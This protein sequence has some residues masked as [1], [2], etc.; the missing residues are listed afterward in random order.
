[1]GGRLLGQ[2]QVPLHFFHGRQ[3]MVAAI[4]FQQLSFRTKQSES[5]VSLFSP[6]ELRQQVLPPSERD[7]QV[8]EEVV[9][10]GR[11]HAPGGC[12]VRR[13]AD[14][15]RASPPARGRVD[16]GRGAADAA[17][18]APAAIAIGRAHCRAAG[19]LISIRRR[20]TAGGRR[21]SR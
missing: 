12:P 3:T 13:V 1:M 21:S 5:H 9:I 20:W 18:D 10:G 6:Q 8:F 17:A 16:G 4:E 2:P 7:F 19:G 15:D 11:E 14:A